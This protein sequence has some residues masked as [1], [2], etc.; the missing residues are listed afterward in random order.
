MAE[1]HS[2]AVEDN[3]VHTEANGMNQ[4]GGL[5][6]HLIGNGASGRTLHALITKVDVLTAL[7]QNGL[8]Q[9]RLRRRDYAWLSHC[10]APKLCTSRKLAANH[11][12]IE[13][14]A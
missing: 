2:L 13:I 12:P 7:A 11:I 3:V 14:A 5:V 1:P 6:V 8:G 9:R 4:F 10:S